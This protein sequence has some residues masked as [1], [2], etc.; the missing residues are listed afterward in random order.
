MD[1]QNVVTQ[2][3]VQGSMHTTT[4]ADIYSAIR[5]AICSTI[6]TTIP[7]SAVHGV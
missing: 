3:G 5:I 2:S 6:Y 4:Y 7:R 1:K